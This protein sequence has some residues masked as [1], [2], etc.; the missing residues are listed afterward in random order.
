[1]LWWVP[2]RFHFQKRMQKSNNSNWTLC[3]IMKM[4]AMKVRVQN[5]KKK[6]SQIGSGPLVISA[7]WFPPSERVTATSIAQVSYFLS[8]FHINTAFFYVVA[9]SCAIWAIIFPLPNTSV[10][11]RADCFSCQQRAN[12]VHW[13]FMY[14]LIIFHWV[15][16]LLWVPL[17]ACKYYGK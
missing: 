11:H 5:T 6:L 14:L 13:I 1:M 3:L 16:N 4:K 9:H 10:T 17:C 12:F 8:H 2:P 15:T 7:V